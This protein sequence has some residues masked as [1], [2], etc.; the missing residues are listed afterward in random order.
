LSRSS[1]RLAVVAT[2]L[3]LFA[4]L[5]GAGSATAATVVNGD[6]ETGNFEGWTVKESNPSVGWF[7]EEESE[8]LTPPFSGTHYATSEQEAP[9]TAYLYQD[10]ALEPNMSHQLQLAFGYESDAPITIPVPDSLTTESMFA[11]QQARI[12][13]VKPTAPIDS[14]APEDILATLFASSESENVE[15]DT[16]EPFL[17][18]RLLT[19]DLSKFAGQT[20]RLR[21]SVAVTEA[22]L[23]AYLDNVSVTSSPLPQ[24]V[25][26]APPAPTPPPSNIFT[27]G[28]VTLNKKTGTA[29]LA[30]TVPDAGTLIATDVHSKVAMGSFA[31]TK[32]K[33]KAK[34]V[35]VKAATV[36]SA[37]AGTI[38]VPIKPTPAAKK[39][40]TEKGK[41]AVKVQLTFAPTGG[42]PATQR[43]G[44]TLVKTLKP[45]RK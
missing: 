10:I 28:G 36:I 41:L 44:G 6:F 38:T 19:A 7:V 3:G 40:L 24:P 8:P 30:V 32:T 14:L 29:T 25:A 17:E 31:K 15:G 4:A 39:I 37:G 13:V 33:P 20:V 35:F 27:K 16:S 18:P 2:T 45:A 1:R 12:D 9:G 11:N 21:A 22:P 43:Y 5:I 26:P 23:F 34:P 42:T